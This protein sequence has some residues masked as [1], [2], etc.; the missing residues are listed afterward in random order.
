VSVTYLF[1]P[2]TVAQATGEGGISTGLSPLPWGSIGYD[3]ADA[4]S[5]TTTITRAGNFAAY[6]YT[7][8][9]QAVLLSGTGITPGTYTIS[10][11]L[12][13]SDAEKVRKADEAKRK[14]II[15]TLALTTVGALITAGVSAGIAFVKGATPPSIPPH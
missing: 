1:H 2:G 10:K 13:L 8:G 4:T 14:S 11:V 6:T 12:L 5:S 15:T 7:S 9:D 3:V